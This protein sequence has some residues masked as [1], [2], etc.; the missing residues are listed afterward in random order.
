M[1]YYF[2]IIIIIPPSRHITI[3]IASPS[4]LQ[5]VEGTAWTVNPSG[6]AVAGY[7]EEDEEEKEGEEE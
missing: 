7:D 6:D 3:S 4:A 1:Y 2:I 5:N